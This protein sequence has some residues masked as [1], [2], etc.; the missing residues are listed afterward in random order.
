MHGVTTPYSWKEY[1]SQQFTPIPISE[2]VREVWKYGL[3][4]SDKQIEQYAKS[5][6]VILSM[7]GTGARITEDK[8]IEQPQ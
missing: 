7:A 4:M 5:A 8:N 6:A 3:G 2:G 1:A